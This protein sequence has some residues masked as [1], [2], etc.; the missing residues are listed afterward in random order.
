MLQLQQLE[1]M[2][3]GGC[4]HVSCVGWQEVS[5]VCHAFVCVWVCVFVQSSMFFNTSL[6]IVCGGRYT[7]VFVCVCVCVCLSNL[8]HN[9]WI[10]VLLFSYCRRRHHYKQR[11]GSMYMSQIYCIGR[12]HPPIKNAF[13]MAAYSFVVYLILLCLLLL[14]LLPLLITSFILCAG[15]EAYL[16]TL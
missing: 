10:I 13:K 14:L 8:V 3:V 7:C 15:D 6:L 12:F 1:K 16:I 4:H 11:L 2:V 9:G 5:W